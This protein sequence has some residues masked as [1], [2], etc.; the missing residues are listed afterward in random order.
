[1]TP[2]MIYNIFKQAFGQDVWSEDSFMETI[3]NCECLANE[4]GA[5]LYRTTARETEILNLA[6]LP[7]AMGKGIGTGLVMSMIEDVMD[8]SDKVFLEVAQDNA[9]AIALYEKCGF[10]QI[11]VREKYYSRIGGEKVDALI[12]GFQ[13]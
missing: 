10:T 3:S 6:V 12:M 8:N 7:S 13:A 1:M 2:D 5:I 4:F 9:S 11:G